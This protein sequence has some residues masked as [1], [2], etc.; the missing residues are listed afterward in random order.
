MKRYIRSDSFD[1]GNLNADIWE[2]LKNNPYISFQETTQPGFFLILYMMEKIGWIDF[3]NQIG[4]I[5]DDML[6]ELAGDEY[7]RDRPNEAY[8]TE[9][10]NTTWDYPE[11]VMPDEDLDDHI[12]W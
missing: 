8:D 9:K 6:G 1:N 7:F 2:S 11:I 12:D 4:W 5:D 3:V 10:D